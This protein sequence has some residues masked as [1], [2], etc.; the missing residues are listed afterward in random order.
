MAVIRFHT[1]S[2]ASKGMKALRD[3]LKSR[4]HNAKAIRRSASR[5][6]Q[7]STHLVINWGM[8]ANPKGFTLLNDI[9]GVNKARNKQ[10]CF[11][12]LAGSGLVEYIPDTTTNRITA[13]NWIEREGN[14]VFSRTTLSGRSGAGIV[15]A[16]DI[17]SLVS[18]PLYVK[19][20][21]NISREI[22]VHVFKD[23]VIDFA[24]KKR[25]NSER[26]EELGITANPNIKN[27]NNGY[28][29]ARA[30]VAI[31]RIAMEVAVDSINA[32]GLD[33]GAVDIILSSRGGNEWPYILE[34]NT[35]PGITGSSVLKYASAVE[36]MINNEPTVLDMTTPFTGTDT[37]DETVSDI[38]DADHSID[39]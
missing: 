17:D 33:F 36:R 7:R 32:L 11:D 22:R 9:D 23:S 16:N 38:N 3:E 29:F 30:G 26:L 5:Y 21:E 15:V 20:I 37:E 12:E 39:E 14:K 35:A 2:M 19:G 24:Q 18:A 1:F 28:I 13:R 31:P 34:V 4:G 27:L 10:R 8:G 25:M 6:R